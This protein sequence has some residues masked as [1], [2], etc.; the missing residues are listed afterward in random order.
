MAGAKSALVLCMDVGFS[1]S[2][3]APGE[4]PPFEF[5]KKVIQKFV[6][7]QVFAETKDELA[8][9]LFGT[10]STKNSLD[11]DDQ[12]QNITVHR[13]L[14]VP[15]FELLEEIQNQIHPESQQADWLDALVVCMD[16]LKTETKEKKCDRLNIVLLTD[17]NTEANSEQLDVIIENLKQAGINLQFFLPFPAGDDEE[18]GGDADGRDPGQPGTGKGLS[19]E[20]KS[21]LDMVKHIMLSLDEE[22]GLGEIYSF[23]KAI[24][25]LCMFKRIERKPMAWPCQLTIGS[26]LPIR[27]V[28]YKAV[29]E[30]KLKKTWTTVDAQTNQKDDVKRETVYCLDDDNE[31]EVQKDDTIQGFRYG[32]DIVPF[33]K[34]DQDQ[35][36]YKH[37]G[38]C[39]AVLGFSKQSML[40]RHQFMGTQVIKIFSAK[41]DEHAGVALSAL[42]RALDELNMVAIVRYAYD[43]RSNPQVGAAFPCIKQDYE[44]LMYVQLPFMEDLR[45]FTFP[46][47]ANNKK[48]TPSDTQL[49]AVDSLIDSMMLVEGDDQKDMFKVHHI[50]NP[51]FQRHFQCLHHRAVNPGTPLPPMEPWLKAALECP[52]V[53]SERCQAPLE[54]I[55]RKFPLTEVEKKKKLKTSAQIFGKDSEE[56]DAKKAKGDEEEEEYSLADIAEGS[57]TSVGSVD[58]ARDFRTLIR[59]KSLPFGEVC[60]Q[61]TRRIEQLLSNKNTHY[62]MKSITCIQAFREQSVKLGDANLYNGYLQSLKRSIPN[63]GLEVFW[64]LLVQDAITLISK[65]EVE[66]STVSK[67]EA[68]QFLVTEE[69]KE[70]AAAPQAEDTGD[71]DDLLD[72]M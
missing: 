35:M 27:I 3:S 34:V 46:S 11:K 12:Y 53:I 43:R 42:I 15:D 51:A 45:Q 68:N 23:R 72:M 71:V 63:R 48:F 25:Q 24:E 40:Q 17:L 33:S 65:D 21:G 20:Q 16:L 61:L 49:S 52:D 18:G 26:C 60:Q 4:E 67:N 55:K 5:A 32:S 19:K 1:M 6:Q 22:D 54:E 31:T 37:D 8:L 2:N 14:M 44:C 10:D 29:T 70:E 59:K 41:D 38:K 58:P 36:K 66:G 13:H 57:V 69:K 64:D 7:R 9:V 39:F 47:L 50:P 62:Y 56:P 28:G 30:E